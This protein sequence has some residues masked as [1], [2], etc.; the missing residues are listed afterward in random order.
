MG[1]VVQAER[2]VHSVGDW[3]GWSV[4]P[5]PT[6]QGFASRTQ[7]WYFFPLKRAHQRFCPLVYVCVGKRGGGRWREVH[8][9][10]CTQSVSLQSQLSWQVSYLG[11][12]QRMNTSY[13]SD[14]LF[15]SLCQLFTLL[16]SVFTLVFIC[17]LLYHGRKT[18]LGKA[19][20]IE[21]QEPSVHG[22][23]HEN[24][25]ALLPRPDQAQVLS[26]LEA[27]AFTLAMGLC[28]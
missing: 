11:Y 18:N 25:F 17:I 4:G 9:R 2:L 8:R 24:A 13:I 20:A 3:T 7:T 12:P 15:R 5:E 1:S 10:V 16:P 22:H 23:V 21:C 26:V 27:V 14:S 6:H 19:Q 28:W